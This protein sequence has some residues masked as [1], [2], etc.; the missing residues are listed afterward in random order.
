MD[1]EKQMRMY[2]VDMAVRALKDTPI[3][4]GDITNLAKEIFKF[5]NGETK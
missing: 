2:A 4:D 1:E 5:I 3:E